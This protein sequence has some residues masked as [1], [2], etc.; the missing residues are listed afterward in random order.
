M[1]MIHFV[2][3]KEKEFL[4]AKRLYKH[5]PLEYALKTIKDRSIWFSDPREWPD[6]FERR[7]L[8]AKYTKKG[9]EVNFL[10]RD[11]IYCTC[12][13]MTASSEAFWKVY[14]PDQLCVEL[15]I[16]RRMLLDEL[17]KL[18]D[19]TVYIGKAEYMKTEDIRLPLKNIPFDPPCLDEVN[20]SGFASRLFMLKRNAFKYEDEMRIL[21]VSR[22]ASNK[23]GVEINYSCLPT[24]LIDQIVID[25]RAGDQ[26]ALFL[27]NGL[28]DYYGFDKT[29]KGV[30]RVL[31]SQLFTKQRVATIELD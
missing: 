14:S 4:S 11:K 3:I 27:K 17:S 26:T 21:L 7:F 2:N 31:K 24:D 15:R 6:P 5:M 28:R 18:T 29:D 30:S 10:W 12:L 16:N 20:S 19:Y 1:G 8:D 9:K 13:S 23:T 22:T 25:P